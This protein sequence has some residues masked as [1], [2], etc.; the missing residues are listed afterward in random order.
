MDIE[1]LRLYLKKEYTYQEASQE[2]FL[3]KVEDIFDEFKANGDQHLL[4]YQGVCTELS[5]NP[6]LIRKGYQF[7][8]N[9]SGDYL[10]LRF[11][12]E[13]EDGKM[14]TDILD[15]FSCSCMKTY[16][17]IF[18]KGERKLLNVSP[19]EKAGF[20]GSPEFFFHNNL[21]NQGFSDLDNYSDREIDISEIESWLLKYQPTVDFFTENYNSVYDQNLLFFKHLFFHI[22]RVVNSIHTLDKKK[23]L[24]SS[25]LDLAKNEK[26]VIKWV[27]NI[28]EV[29]QNQK[30][31]LIEKLI[32]NKDG[33][34]LD[35][36]D[37]ILVFGELINRLGKVLFE[38]FIPMRNTLI[39]KYFSYTEADIDQMNEENPYMDQSYLD[40]NLSHHLKIR[41][42]ALKMGEY[43]PL[44]LKRKIS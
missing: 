14:V 31:N 29:T 44:Y 39:D 35:L 2:V 12:T 22:S 34:L 27:L 25:D 24:E 3:D 16:D 6:D 26:K 5:C 15:I 32:K 10:S 17:S 28:E 41:N 18:Q 1:G 42:E 38:I 33:F 19:F 36:D 30:V 9:N 11:I 7:V 8:G 21:I 43:I 23:L 40:S 37:D 4:V 20:K 13:T